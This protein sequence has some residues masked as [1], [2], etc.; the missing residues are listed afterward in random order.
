ML[1]RYLEFSY[2][3]SITNNN[4]S[5]IKIA[6]HLLIRFASRLGDCG[7]EILSAI[8]WEQKNQKIHDPRHHPDIVPKLC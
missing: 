7:K 4:K 5:S 6:R 1:Q 3:I 8:I 2:K